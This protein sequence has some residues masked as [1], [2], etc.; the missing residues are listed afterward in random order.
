MLCLSLAGLRLACRAPPPSQPIRSALVD[1]N[2]TLHVADRE[3]EGSV[4]ALQRLRDAGIKCRSEQGRACWIGSHSR[5]H[6]QLHSC[7]FVT[8]TTKD[9]RANLLALVQ[10]LGFDIREEEVRGAAGGPRSCSN[11]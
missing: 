11:M 10:R 7:R 3:I 4:A 5:A 9:T 2:G 1:L 8:N 6:C